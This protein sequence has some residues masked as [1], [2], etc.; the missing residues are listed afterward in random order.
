[1]H[2]LS[3]ND[4][5]FQKLSI[6]CHGI[7]KYEISVGEEVFAGLEICP[8]FAHAHNAFLFL[9]FCLDTR[10]GLTKGEYKFQLEIAFIR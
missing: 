4:R 2:C 10:G 6:Q 7:R 8:I 3:E 1:M 9:L 5:F